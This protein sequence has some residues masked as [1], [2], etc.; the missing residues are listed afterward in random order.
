VKKKWEW[1]DKEPL[2]CPANDQPYFP[3]RK[4]SRQSFERIPPIKSII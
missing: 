2:E 1:H 4:N 3:T